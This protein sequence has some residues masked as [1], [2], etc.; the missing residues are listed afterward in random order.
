[1][2]YRML[3]VRYTL[4]TYASAS[5]NNIKLKFWESRLVLL[6]H[7]VKDNLVLPQARY[8]WRNPKH[9]TI[10]KESNKKTKEKTV[11]ERKEV[12]ADV[13]QSTSSLSNSSRNRPRSAGSL[14]K[15]HSLHVDARDIGKYLR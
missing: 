5:Q 11:K 6:T 13:T 8:H 3:E 10:K 12:H 9:Q 15:G 4:P 14:P 7:I 1:M 2:T